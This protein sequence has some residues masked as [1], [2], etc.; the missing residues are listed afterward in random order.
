MGVTHVLRGEDHVSNTAVQ[1]QM[2]TA[3][4]ARP[5]RF[6]H[7]ALLVGSEGK[8]S[9]RLGS[10]GCDAF[11]TRGIEPAAVAALLARLGT[12]L[13]VVP[14]ADQAELVD[15]FDLGTFGR[16]PARFDETELDR[17]NTAIV[18]QMAFA[19]VADRLPEGMDEAAWLAIRPNLERVADAADWWRVITGPIELPAFD[20]DTRAY[21][22]A[23][24]DALQW[25]PDTWRQWTEALKSATGRKGKAL[26][27]PLR[28][29]LT[30][31]DSG[32]EMAR[33]LP[34]LGEDTV[35]R[36]LERAA[37]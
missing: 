19:E 20:A 33:L 16:A 12:S 1:L 6:A 10:L 26:F 34:L 21:L 11:R 35:R 13:P 2:F 23:A 5:P 32:P 8:L 14:I 3:L 22:Q 18:H 24:N 25:G 28:Q 15:S 27:L 29:A 37:G 4:G 7:E 31:Q 17:L 30:G 36:R 9:K